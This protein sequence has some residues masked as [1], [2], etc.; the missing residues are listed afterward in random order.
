MVLTE[1]Y[2][3][4]GKVGALIQYKVAGQVHI[5][6]GALVCLNSDGY[7]IPGADTSGYKFI[8][9]AYEDADNTSGS[10]GDI[11]VR[12]LKTGSFLYPIA[13]VQQSDMGDKAYIKDD[14]EVSLVS[15]N[16]IFVGYIC[17]MP[18]SGKVRVRIDNA[19]Q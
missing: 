4:E 19:V 5:Y 16:E 12:V 7:A 2:E 6:K 9:V 14:G 3:A 18:S 8:G 11:S 17:E 15:V 10:N 13:S 1:S